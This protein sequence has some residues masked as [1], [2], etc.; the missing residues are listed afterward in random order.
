MKHL[1]TL[2]VHVHYNG[3]AAEAERFVS[4]WRGGGIP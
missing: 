2:D 4:A 1:R 3:N